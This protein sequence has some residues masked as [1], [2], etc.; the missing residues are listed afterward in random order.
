MDKTKEVV[1][2]KYDPRRG[3][4]WVPATLAVMV[5]AA[6]VVGYLTPY[7]IVAFGAE[8]SKETLTL[9]QSVT[10]DETF[11]AILIALVSFWAGKKVYSGGSK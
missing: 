11:N 10:G 8:T 1:E 9:L 2:K 3:N 5:V 7:F 6:K 4:E